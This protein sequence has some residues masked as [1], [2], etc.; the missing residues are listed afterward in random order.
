MEDFTNQISLPKEPS[1]FPVMDG[2]VIS[3]TSSSF[4]Q[5]GLVEMKVSENYCV[6]GSFKGV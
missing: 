1:D 3:S 2:D 4:E 6:V 5:G